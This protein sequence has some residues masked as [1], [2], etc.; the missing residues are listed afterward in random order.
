M[1]SLFF[2]THPSQAMK[3]TPKS[4]S[5]QY[6]FDKIIDRSTSNCVKTGA[7]KGVFGRADLIPL[8]VADMDFE[9]PPFIIDALQDRLRHPVLGYTM[10]PQEYP[11]A[12]MD[13]V[14]DIH[15]WQ[16]RKE[17][18]SYIPG[19][20]K[21]IALV[22]DALTPKDARVCIQ[23]PVYHPF[24]LVP[25]GLGREVVYNPLILDEENGLYRMDFDNLDSVTSDPRCKVL[26]LSNPHNPS[27]TMWDGDTLRRVASI[28]HRNG[29][30]VISDEIH[31]EMALWGRPHIPYATVSE[32]AAS[33][34]I[35]FMAPTKTFN[36]A[37]VVS[38]YSIIPD[39]GLRGKF[40][41]YL[42]AMEMDSPTIFAPIA[43][44]AAYSTEGKEWRRQM[45]SYIEGNIL[46]TEKFFRERIPGIKVLR[47]EASYLV[48][49]D[50]RGLGLDHD[51]LL[52]LFVNKAHLALNDGE[53]FGREGAGFMRLNVG[54]P[55]S[56]LEKAYG[57]LEGALIQ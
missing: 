35:T 44:M 3:D 36:I 24:R 56:I 2:I 50:C 37:G 6:D 30:L 4:T 23:S 1:R 26:I 32:E 17:W 33:G 54:C 19:I 55:R 25:Q 27:G 14:K 20:V 47:P 40:H 12:I 18:L 5:V 57:L 11:Q 42:K 16:V 46:F 21:G 41:S 52:D 22:I 8:W 48:W 29:V 49:L 31:C 28:C 45:L 7:L 53:M 38:S 51:K 34:S 10:I 15:H 39:D 13:W 9:T 43:T